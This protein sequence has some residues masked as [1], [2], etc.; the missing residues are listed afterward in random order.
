MRRQRKLV[1]DYSTSTLNEFIFRYL[2]MIKI[3]D[4]MFLLTYP[5]PLYY[6]PFLEDPRQFLSVIRTKIQTFKNRNISI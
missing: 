5:D 4:N 2:E 1:S 6:Q 3:L